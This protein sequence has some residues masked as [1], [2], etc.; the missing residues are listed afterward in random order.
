MKNK[1]KF[2][3]AWANQLIDNVHIGILVVDKNRNNL[4]INS[5]MVDMFG[6]SQHELLEENAKVFHVNEKSYL[7][8]GEVAFNPVLEG[9]PVNIDYEFKKK[10]GS[11]FWVHVSGDLVTNQEEVLWTMVDITQRKLLETEKYQQNQL[12]EQIQD[13]IVITDLSAIITDWNSG[14]KN[15]LGYDK[16]EVL[17]LSTEEMYLEEDYAIRNKHMKELLEKGVF[18]A[19]RKLM[20]KCGDIIEVDLTASIL[21]DVDGNPMGML[22]YFKDITNRKKV[23]EKMEYLASHDTLTGLPNRMLFHDRLKQGIKSAERKKT[24]LAL[25]FID[26]DHF[27]EINDA[28][29]HEVGDT[30]LKEVASRLQGLLRKEDTVSR[31]GGDEFTVILQEISEVEDTKYLAKKILKALEA[32]IVIDEKSL[33][34]SSSIGISIYPNDSLES[35]NL[36]KCADM[37]MYKAKS[38]GRNNYQLYIY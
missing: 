36:L 1:K 6:Y 2:E 23:Q 9:K 19:E 15:M 38:E 3:L 33:F 16:E 14:A 32:P 5:R 29:G 11:L 24:T 20:S 27:K 35:D 26:L 31:L 34:V 21:K 17:G 7:H 10:D 18:R 13:G 12:I 8:F 4:F 25:L 37:A 30:V 28:L 22:G